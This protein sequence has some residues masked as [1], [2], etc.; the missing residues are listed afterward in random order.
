MNT[1]WY[2]YRPVRSPYVVTS[3]FGERVVPGDVG[4]PPDQQR[5]ETHYGTDYT[6]D[7]ATVYA[8]REGR[9]V[10]A[11]WD[12]S[13]FGNLV[14]LDH[15]GG[16]TSLYGHLERI[17]VRAGDTV[18]SGQPI[19]VMGSTGNSTG[20]HLHFETRLDNVAYG[21]APEMRPNLLDGPAAAPQA[22]PAS[23][24][25]MTVALPADVPKTALIAFLQA[26]IDGLKAS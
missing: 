26:V 13:G 19:G 6:A 11:G 5:R 17:G 10:I 14:K 7:E 24:A 2:W 20:R 25:T 8:A 16:R 9:V 23:A 22:P 3:Q 15:G 12:A 18:K 1:P 4:K 21:P